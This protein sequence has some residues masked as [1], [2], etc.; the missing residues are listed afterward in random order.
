MQAQVVQ[1][2]IANIQLDLKLKIL[3]TREAPE[4]E[5]TTQ[6]YD[7][8]KI[9]ELIFSER[10]H[11]STDAHLP[12]NKSALTFSARK[13]VAAEKTAFRSKQD[14][15]RRQRKQEGPPVSTLD[16]YIHTFKLTN[17]TV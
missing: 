9:R 16:P 7:K 12:E 15:E 11:R 17:S 5:K 3:E 2:E 13:Q 10:P 8:Q 6:L 14:K 1:L 4:G